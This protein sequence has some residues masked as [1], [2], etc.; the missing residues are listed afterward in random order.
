MSAM[1]AETEVIAGP[2]RTLGGIW[3]KHRRV[4]N[5]AFLSSEGRHPSM[6]IHF[7]CAPLQH[8]ENGTR[9]SPKI[10]DKVLRGEGVLPLRRARRLGAA[11]QVV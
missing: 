10:D 8:L 3:R 5:G 9:P 11:R 1:T 2:P 6:L 4:L 7:G